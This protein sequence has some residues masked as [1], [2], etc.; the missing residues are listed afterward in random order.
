MEY[1]IC[2]L[3]SRGYFSGELAQVADHFN[4]SEEKVEELL[5]FF[6][7]VLFRLRIRSTLH[8]FLIIIADGKSRILILINQNLELIFQFYNHRIRTVNKYRTEMGI[9]DKSGRKEF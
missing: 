4:V 9:P 3:D 6:L 7:K 8:H 5:H 2:S 1:L